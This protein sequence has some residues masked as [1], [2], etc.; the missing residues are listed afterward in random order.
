M[1]FQGLS[2]TLWG[3]LSDVY[4][5][6]ITYIGTFVVFLGA[7]IGLAETKDYAQ[8]MV[9][10][11][12]QSTGSASTVAIGAGVIGDITTREERGSY[13]G[14]FQAGLLMPV[15]VG[16][17]LGGAFANT[18]GWRPIFCFLAIYSGAF[19]IVLVVVLPE[20]LRSIV[21]NGSIPPQR[22]WAKSPLAAVQRRRYHRQRLD[23]PEQ[24][25]PVVS[26]R[27]KI[28]ILGT[29]RILVRLEV[30]FAVFF[31]GIFYT[32]WQM[33]LTALSTLF[34][35][36]YRLSEIETGLIFIA[37]GA[38][39]ICGTLLTGKLL[40]FD[41]RRI[42]ASFTSNPDDFPLE[43]ARLRPVWLYGGLQCA[44]VLIFGWTIEKGVHMSVPII[45]LFVLGW[46]AI[47][48][49]SIVSTFL[50]D[51]Y[52]QKSA[53]AMAALNLVRCLLGA[54]GAAVVM[55]CINA[56]N[57][58]WTFTL[59]MFIMLASFGL[60]VVQMAYGASW[61]RMREQKEAEIQ[62]HGP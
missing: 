32:V 3:A 42:K 16:P 4:G 5:R 27:K 29:V 43:R 31:I 20:T 49:Q 38:G 30:T 26:E 25:S 41:Y 58:G 55:P 56:M 17:I 44:S 18:L 14:F 57:V 34:T 35:E 54:G 19:L 12:V 11:C 6:R 8:L 40:D 48:M 33:V 28:D 47:S 59:F 50:V 24:P 46:T 53:S 45:C 9:L 39:C 62:S 22:L 37:N 52:P 60:V 51:V 36:H 15:A 61:R 7:C 13:M 23:V 21:G 1:I 2:P 10:R